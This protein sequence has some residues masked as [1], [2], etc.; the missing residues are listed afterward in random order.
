MGR[1]G[2]VA[3]SPYLSGVIYIY[4][5]ADEKGGESRETIPVK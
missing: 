1:C 5:I 4:W 2:C 3:K